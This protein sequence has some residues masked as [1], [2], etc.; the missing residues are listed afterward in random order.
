MVRLALES[1][2][3]LSHQL[4]SETADVRE[5]FQR[6]PLFA[7]TFADLVEARVYRHLLGHLFSYF[8]LMEIM[9]SRCPKGG[10]HTLPEMV[11]NKSRWIER[12]LI[13]LKSTPAPFPPL[14]LMAPIQNEADALG[15][16][17]FGE[18]LAWNSEVAEKH[19]QL[20]LPRACRKAVHF[21]QAY[22]RS[23]EA[24]WQRFSHWLDHYP[25][26]EDRDHSPVKAARKCFS[27]LDQWLSESITHLG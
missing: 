13:I 12:D 21:V 2:S 10:H 27:G 20:A 4:L 7:R 3:G 23:R 11:I 8:R 15:V 14:A 5:R 18:Y 1:N 22:G 26:P 25:L 17:F 9:L 16:S 6:N 19:L 24:Q